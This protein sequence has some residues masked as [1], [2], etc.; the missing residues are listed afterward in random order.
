[1]FHAGTQAQLRH[2]F[3][4]ALSDT[5]SKSV[6]TTDFADEFH[7]LAKD[8]LSSAAL[9]ER[10]NKADTLTLL[11]AA[12]LVVP[13]LPHP[14]VCINPPESFRYTTSC[15]RSHAAGAAIWPACGSS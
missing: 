11:M 7:R 12:V 2:C 8:R 15:M 13:S 6:A 1:M 5:E 4:F 14:Q 3:E 10:E 9:L